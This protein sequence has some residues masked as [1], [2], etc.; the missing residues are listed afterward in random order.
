[1][2]ITNNSRENEN[3]IKAIY[4]CVYYND[5]KLS[6]AT[7]FFVEKDNIKYL[8]TSWHVVSGRHFVTKECLSDTC[9]IPNKMTIK[10]QNKKNI[11][12]NYTIILSNN[13]G[14]HNWLEHKVYGSDIDVVAIPLPEISEEIGNKQIFWYKSNYELFVT[15]QAF[16]LGYPFGLTIGKKTNPHA[17]WTSG[18]VAS[19]PC[20]EFEVKGKK[21]PMFLIDSRTRPGQ[22]GAPV[23]YYS[24]EGKDFHFKEN[25]V[26]I[27]GVPFMQPIGIYSGRVNDQ[28]DLGYVWKWKVIEE[29]I[30]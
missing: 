8:I 19:D 5:V 15:E 30:S 29:I 6:T 3:S 12:V 10:Y 27:F 7:G 14:K 16:V 23:I 18:T 4:I 11:W 22:S 21:R 17:I 24:E 20:L 26:A 28:S 25:R 13:E 9:A 2:T 1:M